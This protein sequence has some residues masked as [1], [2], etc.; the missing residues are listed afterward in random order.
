MANSSD[1]IAL[2]STPSRAAPAWLDALGQRGEFAAGAPFAPGAVEPV[3]SAP[4][5]PALHPD[6]ERVE[7]D[8][9]AQAYAD[10]HAAGRAEIEHT[11]TAQ[12]ALRLAL[13][14]LD[15]AA[16]DTLA[17]ELA[18]TVMALCTQVIA[19]HTIERDALA[20]R[21]TAAAARIGQAASQ[22]RLRLHPDDAALIEAGDAGGMVIEPDPTLERGSLVLEGPDG[23][24][25][26]GPAE[27]RRA[28][29]AALQR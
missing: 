27:W 16:L 5:P 21:C 17:G 23:T 26:D 8:A 7:T 1:W 13:R 22:C 2:A 9:L 28:I 19:E 18:D 12:R 6:A 29:A 4:H 10:G 3:P 15:Q 14:E 24:V 25:R 20:Q 11:L